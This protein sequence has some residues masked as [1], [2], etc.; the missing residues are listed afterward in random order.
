M[1]KLIFTLTF[2]VLLILPLEIASRAYW[3][4]KEHLSF[5]NP[6]AMYLFYP[7]L[8]DVKKASITT[9]D[10]YYDILLLGGSVLYDSGKWSGANALLQ[11]K[12]KDKTKLPIR[13]HNV[14]R[15]GHSSRDSVFKYRFLK[16]KHFDLIIIY[17]SINEVRANNCPPQ[18]FKDDYSHYSWYAKLN[19]FAHYP[20]FKFFTLP[21]TV[22]SL[23][24]DIRQK[25]GLIHFVPTDI[26]NE[27]WVKY[28]NAIKSAGPFEKNLEEILVTS[29][30]RKEPVLIASFAF[31]VPR[32]YTYFKFKTKQ[33][34][35]G[36]HKFYIEIWGKPENVIMGIITHNNVIK[37]LAARHP[38]IMFLDEYPNMP[39]SKIYFDDICHL[40]DAGNE[41]LL[42]DFAERIKK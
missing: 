37:K 40:T 33:L 10:G 31:H 2:L 17:D 29:Q 23:N 20:F 25:M 38:E 7:A 11:E 9:T 16:D 19:F 28:G 5:F 21:Y 30:L 14:A 24:I 36:A 32:D 3:M 41:K 22:Y 6:E 34:D 39:K 1:K 8:K 27:E 26:P 13:I 12:L 35:Y 4:I 42:N 15:P 18:M